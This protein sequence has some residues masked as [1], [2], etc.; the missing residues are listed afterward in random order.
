[1]LA[2][3]RSSNAVRRSFSGAVRGLPVQHTAVRKR[4]PVVP[5]ATVSKIAFIRVTALTNGCE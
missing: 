3:R 4:F 2:A 5:I 1:M